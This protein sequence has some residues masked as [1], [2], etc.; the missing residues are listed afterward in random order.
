MK[1]TLEEKIEKIIKFILEILSFVMMFLS[2]GWFSILT[3]TN[4]YHGKEIEVLIIA[5]L[6]FVIS[7]L[8][9]KT[10]ITVEID[11]NDTTEEK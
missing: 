3:F 4:T 6:T 2:L 8:I 5:I 9:N 7:L 10:T 1:K 11:K